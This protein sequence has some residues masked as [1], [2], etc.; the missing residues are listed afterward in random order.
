[1][2]KDQPKSKEDLTI[3]LKPT[4]FMDYD[5]PEVAQFAQ[6]RCSRGDSNQKMAVKLYYAVRDEIR[7]DPYDFKNDRANFKASS[8]LK[9][10]SGYCVAKAVLL[11]A[12]ARSQGI[13][14][15]LGFADVKNHLSTSR[16]RALMQTD[17]FMYHG[18]VELL[19]NNNWV[20]ATPAFNL[21]L[22]THFNV[23]P[24]EFDGTH[25]SLFHEFDTKGNRHMEYLKDH[26]HFSDLPFDTIL[27]R[28]MEIYPH[29]FET[30]CKN[31]SFGNG[32]YTGS[33]TGAD[34][35]QEAVDENSRE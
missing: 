20:K 12:A 17:V 1:M 10:M 32:E 28:C 22:C 35:H 19:L 33:L 29:F 4:Y 30:T 9:K 26:G 13:P 3:F 16:L 34:F 25:D 11:A 31:S 8:V 24:L 27:E 5:I 14:A 6:A 23:K 15:R 2:N 21:T 18:Y 7:Y